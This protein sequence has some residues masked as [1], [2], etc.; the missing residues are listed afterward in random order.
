M[1]RPR[2]TWDEGDVET[3][4][5]LCK[6]MCTKAEICSVMRL[7]PKTL[8]RLVNEALGAEVP[9]DGERLTFAEAFEALSASGRMSIRRKQF[10]MA[11]EGDRTMLVWL[12]KNYLGQSE[13][14]RPAD[15][16][17]AE[18]PRA[19]EK[20]SVLELAMEGRAERAKRAV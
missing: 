11:M 3:F 20:A 17:G 19:T 8:D 5:G 7:D 4:R 10:E 16:K 13:P 2:R 18:E 1:G 15:G 14:K 6:I 12:G 9:H